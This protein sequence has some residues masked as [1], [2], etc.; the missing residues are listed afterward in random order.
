MRDVVPRYHPAIP[1]PDTSQ[2]DEREEAEAGALRGAA[3]DVNLRRLARI[4]GLALLT[5]VVVVIGVLV[6]AGASKNAQLDELHDHGLARDAVVVSCRSNLGGSGSNA[7]GYSCVGAYR[8]AGHRYVTALPGST[9][10][11][12]GS[13]VRVVVASTD[14]GLLTTPGLLRAE[15]ASWRV[16]LVP[17]VLA[18]ALLG[19]LGVLWWRS[20]RAGSRRATGSVS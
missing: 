17:A 4:L 12:P 19:A 16:Y 9:L 11:A 6:A 18:G 2:H 7:V 8:V 5:G 1:T 14:P 3:V 20:R 15:H 13:S 10:L